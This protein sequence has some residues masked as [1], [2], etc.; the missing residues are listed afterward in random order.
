M[1]WR[2]R[3]IRGAT[4]TSENSVQAIR[5]VVS[6]LLDELEARNQI[7]ANLS[8]SVIFIDTNLS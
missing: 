3:A 6:E 2:V 5:E 7:D 8:I 4:T 1:E